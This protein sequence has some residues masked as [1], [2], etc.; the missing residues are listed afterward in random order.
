MCF[1]MEEYCSL[2]PPLMKI[3]D[4]YMY[5]YFEE[6]GKIGRSLSNYIGEYLLISLFF[7][8]CL[9]KYKIM[10]LKYKVMLQFPS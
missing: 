8:S 6:V 2:F 9:L 1:L 7:K 10:L 3:T 4:V 5:L